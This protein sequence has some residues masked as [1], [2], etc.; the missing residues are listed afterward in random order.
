[1]TP[2]SDLWY[3]GAAYN[4][5]PA[6]MLDGQLHQLRFKD[7]DNKATLLGLR[8]TYSFSKRTAVYATVGHIRNDGS[9]ALSVSGGAPGAN[10][11]AG[12]SQTGVMIGMRHAF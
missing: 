10:P 1:M 2:R 7:S 6:F 5:T 9:L 11:L 3:L 12:E 4:L 8:G